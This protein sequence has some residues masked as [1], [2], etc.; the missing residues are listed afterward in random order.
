MLDMGFLPEVKRI[1]RH[2]PKPEQTLFFSATMPPPI[3]KLTREILDRPIKV[4]LQRKAAPASGVK[5]VAYHVGGS[6]KGALLI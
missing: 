2:V 6:L 5:Q 1:L 3:E 4:A